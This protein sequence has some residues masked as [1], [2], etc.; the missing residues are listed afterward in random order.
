M[1]PGDRW[2]SVNVSQRQTTASRYR[3]RP[4]R[5]RRL[6][7][8]GGPPLRRMLRAADA[9][10][11]ADAASLAI[12][13]P[14]IGHVAA[15]FGGAE[16][17]RVSPDGLETWRSQFRLLSAAETWSILGARID[18]AKPMFGPAIAGRFAIARLEP[19]SRSGTS[20][21]RCDRPSPARNR[22]KRRCDLPADRTGRRPLDH[23]NRASCRRISTA[24]AAPD[25]HCRAEPPAAGDTTGRH[26]RGRLSVS[27]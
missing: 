18:S 15:H 27:P 13:E 16:T 4:G 6:R 20:R 24:R 5:S 9:E 17:T 10:A 12:L 14:I 3:R 22:R 23:G 21:A 7:P 25:L 2:S 1:R 19:E 11:E 26:D 8:A